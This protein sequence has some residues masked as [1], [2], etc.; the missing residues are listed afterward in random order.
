VSRWSP[1]A[2]TP[3]VLVAALVIVAPLPFGSTHAWAVS[4]IEVAAFSLLGV[5]LVF[6]G[7]D[8]L[9]S[10]LGTLGPTFAVLLAYL[11]VQRM[12]LPSALLAVAS[13]GTA[14]LYA[15]LLGNSTRWLP[16]SL[17]AHASGLALV[18]LL[19]YASVFLVVV[20]APQPRRGLAV[21]WLWTLLAA[22]TL[23]AAVAWLH[24]A[25][26]WNAKLFGTFAAEDGG[27]L[28]GRLSWPFVN[29]NHLA[30]AMNL[31]WPIALGALLSPA[32]VGGGG[33]R[34]GRLSVRI[35]AAVLLLLTV[36]TLVGTR[37]RGGLVAAAAA[38]LVMSLAWPI[39]ARTAARVRARVAAA[40][41]VAL[42]AGAA[43]IAVDVVEHPAAHVDLAALSRADATMQIRLVAIR[44]SL[45][46]LRDFPL[47]GTGLGTW[48]EIF[49]MYQG[50]PLLA[51]GFPYAHNE[52][53]QWFEETGL[54]GFA[55]LAALCAEYLSAVLRPVPP[56]AA[57][58]RAIL[59]ATAA[60]AAVHSVV[61]FG[62][63]LPSNALLFAVVL[64]TLWLESRPAE[65][66]SR[67]TPT[68][69]PTRSER[70]AAAV[71]GLVLIALLVN[72][73]TLEWRGDGPDDWQVLENAA[74]HRP[75]QGLPDFDL[76]A[77][78]VAAAPASA[79]AHRTL[80]YASRSIFMR[81]LELRRA[82]RCAPAFET[83][84]L[85]LAR[86]LA[87]LGRHEEAAKEVER[88]IYEDP[89]ARP[90][91]LMSLRDVRTGRYGYREAVLRGLKRRGL[92]SPAVA[93]MARAL[94]SAPR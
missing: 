9:R 89:N 19:A 70:L 80:A 38:P 39:E 51:V 77:A 58:R 63:R 15:T 55:L 91:D 40:V 36:A 76:S 59:L 21:F 27:G 47:F 90:S 78:A 20:A 43:W 67:A 13:P 52:Y 25:L 64:G 16:L 35:L 62:L 74:W 61:D 50:Y 31:G 53:V 83:L 33:T 69:S 41:L 75:D 94:E 24:L 49:P 28:Y 8:G 81:E 12:P 23:T 79:P 3:S 29:M 54:I 34:A 22:A 44:Q 84:R 32:A 1:L 4:T 72:C 26:G 57:R 10:S 68:A 45:G 48:S 86:M 46:M 66:A 65:T 88:A 37:S 7:T 30:T 5:L 6:R 85:D 82:I 73:G 18:R 87:A 93:D 60:A 17:D 42:I 2:A 71:A 56:D 11:C 14:S 92:E